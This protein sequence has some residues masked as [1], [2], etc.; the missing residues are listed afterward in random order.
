MPYMY[1]LYVC[2]ICTPCMMPYQVLAQL[3][4][5]EDITPYMRPYMYALYVCLICTPYMYALYY[6]RAHIRGNASALV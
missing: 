6:Q 2:L 1:A 3:D 5:L 4:W